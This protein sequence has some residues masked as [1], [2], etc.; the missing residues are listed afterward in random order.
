MSN[1]PWIGRLA[2]VALATLSGGAAAWA[3][4]PPLSAAESDPV[5]MGWMVGSPPP[6]DKLILFADG[7]HLRFPQ[8]RWSVANFRR[9]M[10]SANVW[11]G[12]GPVSPLPRALRTDI[13]AV[14]FQPLGGGDSD[15]LGAVARC[16]LHGRDH[17]AAQGSRGVRAL[18]GRHDAALATHG[19]VG[20]QVDV[21]HAG[22]DAGGGGQARRERAG[23]EVHSRACRQWLGR[24]DGAPGAR[25]DH[26]PEVLGELRRSAGRSLAACP[27]RRHPAAPAGLRRVPGASTNSC[28]RCARRA[29][30]A[31]PSPTRR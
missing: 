20:H 10:P 8:L 13:D 28:A 7:S 12:D 2:C 6:P 23:H 30:T 19:D 3:Q 21:R 25:H 15:D 29:S 5:K 26:W 31:R 17:R 4:S 1:L 18:P 14:K 22:R 16:Q 27:R 9:F 24:R 11:R